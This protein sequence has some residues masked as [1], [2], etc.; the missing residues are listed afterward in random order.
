MCDIVSLPTQSG[1]LDN[2]KR[3]E[4]MDEMKT[5][6]GLGAEGYEAWKVSV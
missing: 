5:A 6:P 4:R 2:E 3:G 1:E